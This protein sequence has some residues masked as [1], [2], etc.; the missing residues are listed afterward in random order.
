MKILN[1]YIF[2]QIFIGFL[3]VCF[4]LLAMLWL[5]QSLK[6]VEMVTRQG[7]PVYLF[8]EMTSLL[9]PRIFNI[10]SP[11]AVFVTVLFVYNRLIADRELVVMQSAGI[12]P[13]NNAKAAVAVGV[14]MA[15]FN[16]FVMNWGI[17]WSESKFRDLEWRVKNNLTQMVF[18]EGEFTSLKNGITVFVNKHEDDGSV[19]GIF[20]SDESKPDVKVTLT[21]EK[22]R[23]IQTEKGPRILFINGVRQEINTKDYKF[24]TL[25]FSRYSAEFN[26]VESKKKKSQTVRERSI[27]DLLNA[28][29]DESLDAPAQRKS[30]VEGH[31]R[32][33]YPMYNLLFALMACVGLLVCNFNRRGQTKIISIEVLC[34]IIVL[35]GDLALTNLCGRSLLLLPVLYLNCLLPFA[36]CLYMLFFYNPFYF[37]RFRAK[38]NHE[39]LS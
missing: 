39:N 29:N 36:I 3:L 28:E 19:S 35:G 14:I 31:R 8:A 6:F 25:S 7:L 21:A 17:P 23:L 37:R 2:K 4:S 9:M 15:L 26:N 12:S 20:V 10:L 11:V 38:E 16:V 32:I 22:G 13:W 1:V 27:W 5:T 18:R 34:M 24:S 33:L 30:I